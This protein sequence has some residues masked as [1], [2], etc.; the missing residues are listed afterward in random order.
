MTTHYHVYITSELGEDYITSF[1]VEQDAKNY[2]D[3]FM[4][5]DNW[6]D[7][8]TLVVRSGPPREENDQQEDLPC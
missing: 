3:I 8:E 4:S 1:E 7:D 6:S 2:C 5:A